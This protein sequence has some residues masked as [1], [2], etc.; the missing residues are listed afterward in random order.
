MSQ[1]DYPLAKT[2]SNK[3]HDRVLMVKELFNS[4]DAN[5]DGKVTLAELTTVR[6]SDL[7]F[8][9]CHSEMNVPVPGGGFWPHHLRP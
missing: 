8:I 3:L 6:S 4:I 5:H 1:Q 7:A 2:R 9:S